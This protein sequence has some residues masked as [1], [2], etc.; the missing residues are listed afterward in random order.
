MPGKHI[1]RLVPVKKRVVRATKAG[2]TSE[3]DITYYVKPKEAKKGRV[4][5]RS[6]DEGLERKK[7][8]N[9]IKEYDDFKKIGVD[10][11]AAK[12]FFCRL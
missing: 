6:K 1:A 10:P 3:A 12:L 9:G 4:R 5:L 7:F 8:M 11:E 2:N